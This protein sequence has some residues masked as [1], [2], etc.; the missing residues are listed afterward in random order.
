MWLSRFENKVFEYNTQIIKIILSYTNSN[1]GKVYQDLLIA[2]LFSS[3]FDFPT[4]FDNCWLVYYSLRPLIGWFLALLFPEL[5]LPSTNAFFPPFPLAFLP[6]RIPPCWCSPGS[7]LWP[8]SCFV[9]STPVCQSHR[10]QSQGPLGCMA[11]KE[12]QV[13]KDSGWFHWVWCLDMAGLY[14]NKTF[15]GR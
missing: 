14:E 5:P 13:E 1:S 4:A 10:W 7:Y 3:L 15:C 6:C 11:C 8:F 12:A 2:N 9:F